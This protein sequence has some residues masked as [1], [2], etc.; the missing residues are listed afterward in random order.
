MMR[1]PPISTLT[2][3][4]FPYTTLFRSSCACASSWLDG[5][6]GAQRGLAGLGK[7]QRGDAVGIAD[8][9]FGA[10][11]DHVGEVVDLCAVG[12]AVAFREA[13]QA[14]GAG[15]RLEERRGGKGRGSPCRSR[16]WQYA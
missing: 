5:G 3:S 1:R 14:R 16:W 15:A 6:A 4:L 2:D 11:V 7:L 10:A 9:R 12:V 8:Q 13:R